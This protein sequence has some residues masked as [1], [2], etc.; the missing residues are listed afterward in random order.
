MKQLAPLSA[1]G[2]PARLPLLAGWYG[3]RSG[4]SEVSTAERKSVGNVKL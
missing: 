2:L 1:P 3:C 4:E